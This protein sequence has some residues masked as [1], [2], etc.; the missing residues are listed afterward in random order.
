MTLFVGHDES[1]ERVKIICHDD[2]VRAGFVSS[3]SVYGE[4]VGREVVLDFLDSILRVYTSAIC[5][6][7][8]L[9]WQCHIGK[10]T[11]VPIIGKVGY[12]WE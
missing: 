4:L 1:E 2:E 5:I 12:I 10:K 7:D 6:V 9:H 11:A 3:K 8:N